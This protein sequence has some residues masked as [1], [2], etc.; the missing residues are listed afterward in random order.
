MSGVVSFS[1]H[2]RTKQTNRARSR[3][4]PRSTTIVCLRNASGS[5]AA[6]NAGGSRAVGLCGGGVSLGFL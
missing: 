3:T 4:N 1:R 5:W 2:L 6:L